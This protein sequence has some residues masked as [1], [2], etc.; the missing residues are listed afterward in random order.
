M[1][2]LRTKAYRISQP[3]FVLKDSIKVSQML[4][5]MG[6][7]RRKNTKLILKQKYWPKDRVFTA[8]KQN[9][10][11]YA[12]KA[13]GRTPQVLVIKNQ[14]VTPITI[15]NK[16]FYKDNSQE[17]QPAGNTSFSSVKSRKSMGTDDLSGIKVIQ[18]EKPKI[19]KESALNMINNIKFQVQTQIPLL[20]LHLI[21]ELEFPLYR[22][23]KNSPTKKPGHQ[24]IRVTAYFN[25]NALTYV[26]ESTQ[27]STMIYALRIEKSRPS[28]LLKF[29]YSFA[30]S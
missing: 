23:Q 18:E 12:D 2:D 5:R 16:T 7:K 1:I 9:E 14:F 11:S 6:H 8:R 22:I 28:I 25:K 29:V 19:P 13:R 27:R 4:K 20:H 15:N 26:Q 3:K 24:S 17:K 30:G 21:L 10:N